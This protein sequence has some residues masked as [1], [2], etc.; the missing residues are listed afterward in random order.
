MRTLIASILG[1][2]LVFGWGAFIHKVLSV[3]KAGMHALSD[4]DAEQALLDAMKSRFHDPGIYVL[5]GVDL[6]SQDEA[7]LKA[8]EERFERGPNA[9]IVY[10]PTGSKPISSRKLGT[11]FLSNV[12]ASFV[13][14]LVLSR[15]RALFP[16]RVVVVML[17]GLFAWLSVDISYWNW[18]R[19]PDEYTIAQVL[20]QG[21]GWLLGGIGIA[22]LVKGKSA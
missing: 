3:G 15:T 13:A 14:A 12:L 9:L 4:Q 18:Y 16:T 19:F 6:D 17:M 8:F 1:G 7:K 21:G 5:P 20:D 11:E 22:A 2:F 10:N